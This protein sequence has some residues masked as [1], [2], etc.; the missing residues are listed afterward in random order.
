M[1]KIQKIIII[2]ILF[3]S[4]IC[5]AD[6]SESLQK[7]KD[8]YDDNILTEDQYNEA[9]EKVLQQMEIYNEDKTVSLEAELSGGECNPDPGGE[10]CEHEPYLYEYATDSFLS[11]Y[12]FKP[13][14]LSPILF[15]LSKKTQAT[16]PPCTTDF[17]FTTQ[18]EY[19]TDE[20]INKAALINALYRH[21]PDIIETLSKDPNKKRGHDYC[22]QKYGCFQVME[23]LTY[24]NGE[25]KRYV[26][27]LFPEGEGNKVIRI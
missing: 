2:C 5:L 18:A 1:K 7:L 27:G 13:E 16:I 14:D 25:T 9:I 6:Q 19:A 22:T 26:E 11:T 4:F 24:E 20:I 23:K 21:N 3:S 10:T 12:G 8:L 15:E 17:C